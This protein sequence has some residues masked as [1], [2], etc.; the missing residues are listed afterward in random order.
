[1]VIMGNLLST[2][3]YAAG[4]NGRRPADEQHAKA[5]LKL[6]PG[7]GQQHVRVVARHAKHGGHLAGLKALAQLQLDDFS[8]AG[9]QA[10]G[11]FL[12]QGPQLG[13][14]GVS[15]LTSAE[16]SVTSGASAPRPRRRRRRRRDRGAATCST[17][18]LTS[19]V[20]G[21]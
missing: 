9:I 14:L 12:E 15:S 8:L 16:S 4:W 21:V 7:P 2:D 1:M 5:G 13:P 10:S 3:C 18:A 11:G 19:C 17:F 6:A 20:N